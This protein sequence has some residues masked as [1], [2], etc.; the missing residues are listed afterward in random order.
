MVGW[1]YVQYSKD[2]HASRTHRPPTNATIEGDDASLKTDA[3]YFSPSE[4]AR[5]AK[6]N[7]FDYELLEYARLLSHKC[8]ST[9]L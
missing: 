1:E 2:Y 3:D 5:V 7:R 6:A 8:D 4:R 9:L